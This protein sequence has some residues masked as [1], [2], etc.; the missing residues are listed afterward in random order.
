VANPEQGIDQYVKIDVLTGL[1]SSLTAEIAGGLNT[2]I[3]VQATSLENL[4][5]RFDWIKD[6]LSGEPYFAKLAFRENDGRAY[7]VR[8]IIALLDLFNVSEFPNSMNAGHPV[9]AY[10]SKSDV[11]DAYVENTEQFEKLRPILKDI[12]KLHDIVSSTAPELYDEAGR[13]AKEEGTGTGAKAGKLSFVDTKQ[14]GEYEFI[15]INEARNMRIANGALMPM[16]A[17]FRWMVE[18]DKRTGRVRWRGGFDNVRRLWK[19]AAAELVRRTQMSS[20]SV[21][22]KVNAIGRNPQHW[23]Q[24][25]D[26]LVRAE[27][28]ASRDE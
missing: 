2:S 20:L 14:R 15:F 5:G 26:F 1:H 7:D 24:L 3:Q 13:R 11:L 6:E 17:A 4:K 22:R 12:L 16:L 10:S 25:Y 18:T 9:R 8:D 28:E 19:R 27:M 23:A 21:D